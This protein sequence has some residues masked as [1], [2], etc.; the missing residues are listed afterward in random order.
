[1][2]NSKEYNV[3]DVSANTLDK[4]KT[5]EKELEKETKEKIV[6][7]AYKETVR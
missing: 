7:I 4:I 5:L 2:E 3:A 1:M 6:L